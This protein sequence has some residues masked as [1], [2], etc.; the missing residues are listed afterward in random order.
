MKLNK[1]FD[2]PSASYEAWLGKTPYCIIANILL[3]IYYRVISQAE[4]QFL[5]DTIRKI[6][7]EEIKSG[8]ALLSALDNFYKNIYQEIQYETKRPR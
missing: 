4:A 5:A 3:D 7:N 8:E 6:C 2:N 1:L